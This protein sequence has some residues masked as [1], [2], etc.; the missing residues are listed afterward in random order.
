[1][2]QKQVL[3]K[4]WKERG[5]KEELIDAFLRI[6]REYFVAPEL[7]KH[8]YDD[9]PLPT[10]RGQSLSQPTTVMIMSQALEVQPGQ[11][12]LEIGSGVGYQASILSKLVQDGT[13]ITTEIIPELAEIARNNLH[14]LGCLNVEVKETDGSRGVPEE[15]PF[16]RVMITAA[17]PQ[18]PEPIID[19]LKEGGIIVAP[20]GDLEE[21]VM[22][23]AVKE[24]KRLEFEFLGQFMFV[25]LQGKYGFEISQ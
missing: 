24:G 23:K 13:V 9:R 20:V 4:F 8:A 15:A 17:C 1:M 19:Q 10:F 18:I 6:P 2:E 12:V 5:I 21:Q 16:D 7:F 3:V 14:Q 25:P 11:K 22:V